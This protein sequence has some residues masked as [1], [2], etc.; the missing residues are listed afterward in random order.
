MRRVLL[1]RP[2]ATFSAVEQ[3]A[4][5]HNNVANRTPYF[6]VRDISARIEYDSGN[7]PKMV[8]NTMSDVSFR[9]NRFAHSRSTPPNP[10]PTQPHRELEQAF[11]RPA[12]VAAANN[13][14]PD[15]R[16]WNFLPRLLSEEDLRD[17]ASDWVVV[18]DLLA[19]D[20]RGYDPVAPVYQNRG[21]G[22]AIAPGDYGYAN[23]TGWKVLG[24]GA[25]VD[26]GSAPAVSTPSS[27]LNQIAP[28]IAGALPPGWSLINYDTW[29]LGYERDGVDQNGNGKTDEGTNGLD[30]DPDQTATING[31]LMP[32]GLVDDP[33]ERETQPPYPVPL[34]GMEVRVR[35]MDV[36]TR[37]IRQTSV[38]G[39]FTR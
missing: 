9:Q 22:L 34:R 26:L 25:Y 11:Q 2:N 4:F 3:A 13:A 12:T 38:V 14:L 27:L 31:P 6:A 28:P 18:S 1:I 24:R 32:N 15:Y 20:L 19:F 30:D 39:D 35:A 8:P 7:S 37:Q 17:F 16:I 29:C 10:P 5:F 36:P 33:D 23:A 21:T